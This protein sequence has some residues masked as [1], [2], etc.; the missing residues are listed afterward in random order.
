ME[1]SMSLK[2]VKNGEK[3]AIPL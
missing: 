3:V 1:S 2:A